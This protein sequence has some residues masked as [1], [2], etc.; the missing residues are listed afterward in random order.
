M[1]I[2]EAERSK[3]G[4]PNIHVFPGYRQTL[5]KISRKNKDNERGGKGERF[6][7]TGGRKGRRVTEEAKLRHAAHSAAESR[8]QLSCPEFGNFGN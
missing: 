2:N 1:P 6:L 4:Q 8:S 5:V 3:S 7:K